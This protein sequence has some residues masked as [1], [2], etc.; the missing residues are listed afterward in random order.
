MADNVE[1]PKFTPKQIAND[2]KVMYEALVIAR[3]ACRRIGFTEQHL[4]PTKVARHALIT[5]EAA[6]QKV[7]GTNE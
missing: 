4:D 6:L 5:I 1:T 3:E 2:Y 7:G